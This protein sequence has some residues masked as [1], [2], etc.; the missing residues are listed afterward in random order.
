MVDQYKL[1][2]FSL[3]A[4][5]SLDLRLTARHVQTGDREGFGLSYIYVVE[6][7]S[8]YHFRS[9]CITSRNVSKGVLTDVMHLDW[10]DCNTTVDCR[11][12]KLP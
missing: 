8:F 9:N 7:P 2:P 10:F 4:R 5:P 11:P 3:I 6:Y 12:F 1:L